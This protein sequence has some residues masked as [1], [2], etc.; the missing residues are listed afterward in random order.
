M[1][2]ELKMTFHAEQRRIEFGWTWEDVEDTVRHPEVSYRAPK[3][4][5]RCIRIRGDI[6]SVVTDTGY[7]VTVEPSDAAT[8]YQRWEH[9]PA[10]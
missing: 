2:D 9:G 7:I 10:T 8:S 1:M 3:Y 4:P 6:K 5:D